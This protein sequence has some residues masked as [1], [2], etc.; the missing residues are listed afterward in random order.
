MSDALRFL[1]P[2]A[3]P[4]TLE[5]TNTWVL[6]GANGSRSIVIDPGPDHFEHLRKV[7]EACSHGI[8]EI[9]VT[10]SHDD[11]VGGAMRLAEWAGC[12]IRA[13]S[14]QV[15]LTDPLRDGEEGVVGGYQVRCVALPGHTSDSIGFIVFYDDGPVMFCGDTILGRGTTQ[16]T[17]P[18]GN[19]AAY[20]ATLDKMERLI[21]SYGIT[22]LMPGHGPIV[23][24]PLD[25]VRSY[26]RHRMNRLEQIRTAYAAGHTSLASLVET[27]YGDMVGAQHRAAEA[28]IRAQLDYLELL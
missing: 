14:P 1:V 16:I 3:N 11:H 18:D 25:R 26:R 19:L 21:S 9:W 8:S 27:V 20:L 17:W 4:L 6:P 28:T 15:S 10:H 22:R 12:S 13:A 2:N 24:D 23:R 5:G 7:R